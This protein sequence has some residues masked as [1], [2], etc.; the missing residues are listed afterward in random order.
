MFLIAGISPIEAG[1]KTIEIAPQVREPLTSAS[2]TLNTPYGKV[3]SS[4]EM[5]ANVFQLSV[6]VPPNTSAKISVPADTTKPLVLKG[7]TFQ[8]SS[9]VKLIH[10]TKNVFEL[11]VQAG[12]YTFQSEIK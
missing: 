9:A 1:Y 6:T 4:W 11:E 2:A 3:S 7:T 5:K 12:T 8:E 10:T